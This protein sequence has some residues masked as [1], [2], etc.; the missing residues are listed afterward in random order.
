[1]APLLLLQFFDSPCMANDYDIAT[2][3]LYLTMLDWSTFWKS[4]NATKYIHILVM[5]SP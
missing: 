2:H 4:H 3:L 1:M 5:F